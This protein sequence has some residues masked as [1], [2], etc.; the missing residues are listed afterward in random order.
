MATVAGSRNALTTLLPSPLFGM[1]M[2]C[3]VLQFAVCV[4][5]SLLTWFV[6]QKECNWQHR[7]TIVL[8]RHM[9]RQ[10]GRGSPKALPPRKQRH[11]V[12]L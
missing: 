11:K 1:M 9:R 4:C 8:L 3:L 6:H 2:R 7:R 10:R 12:D 5:I